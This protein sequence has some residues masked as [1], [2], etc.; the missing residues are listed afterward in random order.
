LPKVHDGWC[1]YLL[2]AIAVSKYWCLEIELTIVTI[3]TCFGGREEDLPHPRAEQS[4]PQVVL[5]LPVHIGAVMLPLHGEQTAAQ[6]HSM[7]T[8]NVNSSRYLQELEDNV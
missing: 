2:S 3:N 7:K 5:V 4:K 6:I 1:N 8:V